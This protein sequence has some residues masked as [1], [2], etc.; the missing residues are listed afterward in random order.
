MS[1]ILTRYDILVNSGSEPMNLDFILNS[2]D[3]KIIYG[4]VWNDDFN[5]PKRVPEALVQVFK[6]G[7]NYEENPLDIKLIGYIITDNSGEFIAGPFEKG[8]MVIF[9]IFKFWQNSSPNSG[10]YEA[11]FQISGEHMEMT[12]GEM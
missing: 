1:K 2:S 9:K 3:K 6:P 8:T 7:E 10:Y 11:S 12:S 5:N 4:T